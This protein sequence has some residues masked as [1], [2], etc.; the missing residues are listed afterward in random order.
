MAAAGPVGVA[1]A[2]QQPALCGLPAHHRELL[3]QLQT[4]GYLQLSME[5]SL[6]EGGEALMERGGEEMRR[7]FG[8]L[9]A[10]KVF[11]LRFTRNKCLNLSKL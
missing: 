7:V 2:E 10:L 5:N 9:A 6:Q 8:E 3:P 11:K 1:C 4:L